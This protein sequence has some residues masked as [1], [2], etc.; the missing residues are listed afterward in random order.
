LAQRGD[1]FYRY[2]RHPDSAMP[3][4]L[5]LHGWTASADLQFFTA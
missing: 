5:L 1:V 3:V 2:H 4:V